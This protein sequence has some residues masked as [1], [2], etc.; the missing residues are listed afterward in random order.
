MT[1]R[2]L[3]IAASALA[4]A[5]G[6]QGT[7]STERED[8]FWAALRTG[9]RPSV[10]EALEGLED[11]DPRDSFGRTPLHWAVDRG[12]LELVVLLLERGASVTARDGAGLTPLHLASRSARV[13]L[14]ERLLA[15]CAPVDAR[16]D[17]GATPL[18]FAAA[19]GR[20]PLVQLLLDHGADL[21][22]ER[23]GGSTPLRAARNYRQQAVA[24]LLA[25]Q[26]ASERR[27]ESRELAELGPEQTDLPDVAAPPPPAR[28]RERI[29]FIQET[30]AELGYAPG[31]ADGRMG[32]RTRSSISRFQAEIGQVVT[33]EPSDCLVDRLLYAWRSAARSLPPH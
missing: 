11:P 20:G 18:H 8:A 16:T 9:D 21:N 13:V 23:A 12:E 19:A 28:G 22:A 1:R 4:L 14:A 6:G 25:E 2:S 26:G 17:D 33:G 7:E 32:P 15:N 3:C 29:R 31:R 30:L 5:A 24:E 10:S 27:V